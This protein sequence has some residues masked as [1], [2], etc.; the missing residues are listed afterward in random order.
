MLQT[1][2]LQMTS[3]P[4]SRQLWAHLLATEL[5]ARC[6]RDQ[7]GVDADPPWVHTTGLHALLKAAEAEATHA[8]G[9]RELPDLAG[10]DAMQ[11]LLAEAR[12][13]AHSTTAH[14]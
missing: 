13:A 2:A 4:T 12:A 11:R 6:Q 10:S 5:R 7:A 9:S 3:L 8:G 14:G 1:L